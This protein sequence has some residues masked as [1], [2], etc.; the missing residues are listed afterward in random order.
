MGPKELVYLT[1]FSLLVNKYSTCE[2]QNT[3]IESQW[4]RYGSLSQA[5]TFSRTT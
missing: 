2:L 5:G 4:P 3:Q 1:G